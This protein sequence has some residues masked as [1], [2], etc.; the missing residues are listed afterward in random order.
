MKSRQE[1]GAA[2]SPVLVDELHDCLQDLL[3]CV[4]ES[5]TQGSMR[6]VAL[7]AADCFSHA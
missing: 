3:L 7:I 2:I 6:K 4:E 5:I 1:G